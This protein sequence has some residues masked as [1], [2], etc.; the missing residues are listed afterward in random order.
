[1][2]PLFTEVAEGCAPATN[3]FL[4]S[5]TREEDKQFVPETIEIVV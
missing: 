5:G 2:H 1:M 4:L 3:S